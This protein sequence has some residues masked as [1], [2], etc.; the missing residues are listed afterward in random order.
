MPIS[1]DLSGYPYFDDDDESKDFYRILFKPSVSVQVR[2]LNQLQDYWARQV[3]RFGDNV[4][5]AGTIVDGC[6]FVFHDSFPYAKLRDLDV[7]GVPVAPAEL[8]G[9]F[10]E[11]DAGLRGFVQSYVDGFESSDPDLKTIYVTY[12]NSG[13]D[14]NTFSFSPGDTLTFYDSRDTLEKVKV[15]APGVGFSNSDSLVVVPALVV[16]VSSGTFTNGSYVTQDSL[17]S[18]LQVVWVDDVSLALSG[19]VILGV[20]PIITYLAN[21]SA[22]SVVWSTANAS[23]IRTITNSA[24][25]TVE[26]VL[27]SGANGGITTD[28]S[29]RVVSVNLTD[30]GSGYSNVPY[31]TIRSANNTTGISAL[32]LSGQN[33]L[34]QIK[35]ANSSASVGNGYAF[36][37]TEGVVYQKGMLLSVDRQTIV[38][39][40]YDQ[41][42]NAVSAVFETIETI[43]DANQDTSLNDPAASY[44]KNAPGADRLKLTPQLAIVPASEVSPDQTALVT[45]SDGQPTQVNTT[46][47]YSTI[48][49][50]MAQRTYEEAGNF[51]LDQFLVTTRS[52][53]NTSLEGTSTDVVVDPGTGYVS[54]YRV[55]TQR[56]YLVTISKGTDVQTTSNAV[57]TLGY[58]SYV[59]VQEVAGV[60]PFET[61]ATVSLR[62]A[63][64]QKLTNDGNNP[65]EAGAEIGTAMIRSWTWESGTPGT[66]SAIYRLYLFNVQMSA[67]KSFK[68][69]RSV[70]CA[71]SPTACGDCVLESDSTGAQVA[72]LRDSGS[73]QLLFYSGAESLQSASSATYTYRT[74][75]QATLNANGVLSVSLASGSESFTALGALSD[76]ALQD[77]TVV[78][79]GGDLRQAN[80]AGTV[81]ATISSSTLTGTGTTFTTSFVAGD[82]VIVNGGASGSWRTMITSI[83]SD[84]SMTVSPALSFTNSASVVSKCFPNSVPIPFGSGNRDS[85]LTGNVSPNGSILTL[86]VGGN[87]NMSSNVSVVV[88]VQRTGVDP[89]TKTAARDRYVKISLANNEGSTAGPWALGIPDAFRLKGVWLDTSSSVSESSLEVTNDFLLDPNERPDYVDISWLYQ[90]AGSSLSLSSSDW[91]LVKFDHFVASGPGYFC[92]SSYVGANAAQ[93]AVVDGLPLANLGSQVST[94]EIPVVYASNG[95]TMDLV[96]YFDFRPI[97]AN[98]VLSTNVAASAPVNPSSTLSFGS[99]DEEFPLPGSSMIVDTNQWLGRI[100]LIVAGKDG[101]IV[102]LKGNPG[103]SRSLWTPPNQ[104]SDTMVLNSLVVPPYPCIPVYPSG[105]LTEVLDAKLATVSAQRTSDMTIQ[106]KNSGTALSALQPT[107][108]TQADIGTIDKRLTSLEYYVSLNSLEQATKSKSVPSSVDTTTE[109]FKFGIFVD[110][111]DDLTL[112]DVTDDT[113]DADVESGFL[114]PSK[115][116]WAIRQAPASGSQVPSYIDFPI[117]SQTSAT[118]GPP[119]P[120]PVVN[121]IANTTINTTPITPTPTPTPAIANT[122]LLKKSDYDNKIKWTS[123]YAWSSAEVVV[124]AT[125][126]SGTVELFFSNDV[127]S[128][129]GDNTGVLNVYRGTSLIETAANYVSLTA[130]EITMLQGPSFDYWFQGAGLTM[131]SISGTGDDVSFKGGGKLTWTHVPSSG[132]VYTIVMMGGH[133]GDN[134]ATPWRYALR[135]PV[136]A[137]VAVNGTVVV[138]P[139]PSEYV[140]VCR[141]TPVGTQVPIYSTVT[142]PA[143]SGGGDTDTT[144]HPYAYTY[145][146]GGG[147]ASSQGGR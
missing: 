111:F 110:N 91:L 18:N 3:E 127:G 61:G 147:S 135:Y 106:P 32:A 133:L 21:A 17:G 22:N 88:D 83:A 99:G 126:G 74:V 14:G 71:T 52:S 38:V 81:S 45:W 48:G 63:A 123:G 116:T 119:A 35:I 51:V 57:V 115:T 16:N 62:D 117:V 120:P 93:Q 15:T 108:Y 59:R 10:A 144:A 54:G 75:K 122:V 97:A 125:G 139:I 95:A 138:S 105:Q 90:K 80:A 129:A 64:A 143:T 43:V 114:V 39:S 2:E 72:V 101:N 49:D 70:Y 27:G 58:G 121:V 94:Y 53:S 124:M 85:V 9:Y 66:P 77:I 134:A 4:F 113:F 36:S 1:T 37:V 118:N 82:Y 79:T 7:S 50:A 42:P 107:R 145:L 26:G 55:Q 20:A 67:G 60:F 41:T 109:R 102:V 146:N 69:V 11:N 128:G 136:D 29:G 84:V 141:V 131:K 65:F 25:G 19:Q 5:R 87:V 68:S 6:N 46:T 98:T 73:S 47:T 78:P 130:A 8:P 30:F 132:Y 104:P 92:S 112:Q 23:P 31:V 44:N 56:N 13:N 33:Y 103:P 76:D 28:A 100:D 137:T 89:S 96:S 40:K 24:A 140:G 142:V 86:S 34:T 12:V